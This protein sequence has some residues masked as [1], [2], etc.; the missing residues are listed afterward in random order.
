[1]IVDTTPV[2]TDLTKE[3][4]RARLEISLRVYIDLMTDTTLDAQHI[5]NMT[6]QALDAVDEVK[7]KYLEIVGKS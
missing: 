3:R 7:A 6:A 2:I 4:A 5:V 1:M